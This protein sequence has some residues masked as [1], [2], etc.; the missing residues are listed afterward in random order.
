MFE[1][2]G[3]SIALYVEL[4]KMNYPAL[5]VYVESAEHV[6]VDGGLG[7]DC[8]IG[9]QYLFESR[10]RDITTQA[11]AAHFSMAIWWAICGACRDDM[12]SESSVLRGT[13]HIKELGLDGMRLLPP[14]NERVRA[15]EASGSM[16]FKRPMWD[17][18]A[19]S[20]QV[21]DLASIYSDHNETGDT[22]D[23]PLI[24]SKYVPS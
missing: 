22:G 1:P 12:Q 5:A 4:G 21:V 3:D 24:Q 9:L 15:F 23:S 18:G 13:Y 20:H 11:F 2:Q 16:L 19:D 17:T 10:A 8:R 6:D 14:L 7:F